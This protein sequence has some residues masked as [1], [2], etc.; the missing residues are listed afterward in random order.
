[1]GAPG[2]LIDEGVQILETG[3]RYVLFLVAFAWEPGK[4]SRTEFVLTGAAGAYRDDSG[5]LTR[6]DPRS[7]SLPTGISADQFGRLI[8]A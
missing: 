8:Q 5:V 6:L 7:A 1:M 4:P 2:D 3:V